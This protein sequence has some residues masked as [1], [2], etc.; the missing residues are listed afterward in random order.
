MKKIFLLFAIL[1][2]N[3]VF[4]S[5]TELDE[6]LENEPVNLEILAT[7]GEDEHDPEI[8]DDDN[9]DSGNSEGGN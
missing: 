2:A 7:G 5:C 8:D 4:T 3:G 1:L 6:N 9:N